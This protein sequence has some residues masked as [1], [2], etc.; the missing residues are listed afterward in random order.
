ME[1]YRLKKKHS[2]DYQRKKKIIQSDLK[3]A[4]EFDCELLP[5]LMT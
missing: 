3:P 1:Q 2:K 4:K 5:Y